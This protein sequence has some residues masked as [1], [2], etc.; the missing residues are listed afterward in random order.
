MTDVVIL[1]AGIAGLSAG[2]MLKQHGIGFKIFEK[3]DY[4]G[5]L[6]RSF[7][8]HG[9]PC[10]FAAHRL[11]TTDEEILQQLLSLVPM[12]RHI[13]R[14]KI[15]LQGKWMRDPLD[16]IELGLNLPLAERLSILG[17]FM[18]RPKE[19]P[20]VSFK[21][22][23]IRRYGNSLYRLFFKPYTEKLFGIPG[24]DISVL[25]ARQKVRL[26]NPLDNLRA[27]TKTKF[28]YFYY[29]IHEG[30]G[31]IVNRL[32][33]DIKEHVYLETQV[34]GLGAADNKITH[35]IYE[36]DGV[37]TDLPVKNLI[38]TIPMSITARMLGHNLGLQYQKVEAVYVLVNRPYVSDNHWIYFIDENMSINRM[39]E[40]KNMSSVDV[41]ENT[42]VVCAEVTQHHTDPAKKVVDDLVR[43]GLFTYEE[44]IDT[45]VV[46]ENFSY[47]VYNQ[48]Y[49]EAVS[50]A[51][52]LFSQYKNLQLVGRAAEFQ[53]RE[54]DDNFAAAKD[55]VKKI[56]DE[57]SVPIEKPESEVVT[58]PEPAALPEIFVV[59]LTYNH[60]EDT[61]E[62]LKSMFESNN[63]RFQLVVVDNGS[64]DGTPVRVREDFPCVHVIENEQNLGVPS[65]Y[66]VGF[67]YALS[68]GAD[69]ILMLNNDTVIPADMLDELL[70]VADADPKAGIVMPKTLY[71]GTD[72]K[73]WSSG[74]RYRAFPP[75][76][77]MDE[78]RKGV[79]DT[80][81]LIEF[82]PSCGLLIHRRAFEKAGLFD[83]GYF[84]LYD[85]WDFSERVRTHGLNIWYA[86]NARL[87][88]KVS[89]TTQGPRS[90]LFW[91]TYGSSVV[92]FWRRHGRPVWASLPLHLGYIIVREFLWKNNRAYWG[93]FKQ[94][95]REGL[96]KPLSSLPQASPKRSAAIMSNNKA[97]DSQHGK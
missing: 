14:S 50:N 58:M 4:V 9:F 23:V 44:V 71:H 12:G 82:A 16:V 15:Y 87:W 88:H 96:Q 86:A 84:F 79:S 64:A 40:F 69:Y 78:R 83:P 28:Q 31:A 19:L 27:N 33:S 6:A 77:L 53:H 20:D 62:C 22:Y 3:Q 89:V 75:A 55:A 80:T 51:R 61:F 52:T 60:Y 13:R 5:G 38:S 45:L 70:L 24:E 76:I 63:Q 25:W 94:G 26:S 36:K 37:E 49:E 48:A 39:V 68:A 54:V 32:Y 81:R 35:V 42:T 8:W 65:G 11:F 46:R 2:W 72:D 91:R 21:N 95:I 17:T 1:G 7:Y 90:S 59:V 47:P 56:V 34:K 10:D 67:E 93:E 30:Y 97:L 66:N 18:V 41:P 74:G 29:P 57:I 73:V 92:R 43:A 85:D